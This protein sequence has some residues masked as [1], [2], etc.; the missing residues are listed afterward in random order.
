[1]IHIKVA[2]KAVFTHFG[3]YQGVDL[4]HLGRGSDCFQSRQ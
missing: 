3:Y 4:S 2:H 1:M